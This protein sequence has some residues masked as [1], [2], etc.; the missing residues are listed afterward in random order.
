MPSLAI[1]LDQA[2]SLIASWSLEAAVILF[3]AR[4]VINGPRSN[5]C[6]QLA[7]CRRHCVKPANSAPGGK[8]SMLIGSCKNVSKLEKKCIALLQTL[9]HGEL[10]SPAEWAGLPSLAVP[11]AAC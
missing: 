7:A 2:Q 3:S 6:T 5:D 4:G 9:L 8:A 1:V 10:K 11:A